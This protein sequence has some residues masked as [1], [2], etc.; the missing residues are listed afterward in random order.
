M[1][2]VRCVDALLDAVFA[3]RPKDHAGGGF[4]VTPEAAAAVAKLHSEQWTTLIRS[5]TPSIVHT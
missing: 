3:T 1:S 2:P 5:V 4:A